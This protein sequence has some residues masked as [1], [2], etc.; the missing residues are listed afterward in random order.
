MNR[1]EDLDNTGKEMR[2]SIVLLICIFMSTFSISNAEIINKEKS[3]KIPIASFLFKHSPDF[4]LKFDKTML[5]VMQGK[6]ALINLQ[7]KHGI[8][9]I[10]K[11]ESDFDDIKNG[12][13]FL[14][15]GGTLSV[16]IREFESIEK[17]KRFWSDIDFKS[18][19]YIIESNS[20]ITKKHI[21]L[22]GGGIKYSAAFYLK[23][24]YI[25]EISGAAMNTDPQGIINNIAESYPQLL[26]SL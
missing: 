18:E 19:D 12:K 9:D 5:M 2:N 3:K 1:Y 25:I 6:E 11:Y 7:K 16:V 15:G 20:V 10:E 26:K 8:I 13:V 22:P 21:R 14:K 24:Q 4:R 23:E 17:A